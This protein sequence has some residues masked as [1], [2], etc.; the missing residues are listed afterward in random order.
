MS[1]E[2]QKTDASAQVGEVSGIKRRPL[3]AQLVSDIFSPIL[4]PTYATALAM[5]IT[6]LRSVPESVRWIVMAIVFVITGLIPFA[7]IA[8]LV[9]TG[10]VS[11]HAISKRSQ[12]FTPMT[13]ASVCY[14]GAALFTSTLGAPLWLQMFFYGAAAAT[15]LDL[16]IT[17]WWKISAHT[18]SIGGLVGLMFCFAVMGL[19]DINIMIMLSIGILLAGLMCTSRLVLGRHTLGQVFAGLGMGFVCCFVAMYISQIYQSHI[20]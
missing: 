10:S 3:W 12:R 5:W 8:I 9:K 2:Q 17:K 6:P 4:V 15:L 16:L 11:D 19:A 13:I 18:T 14:I 1:E 20:I 7:I